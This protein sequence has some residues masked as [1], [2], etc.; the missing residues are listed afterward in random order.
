MIDV[1]LIAD[2]TVWE[3]LDL[4][5]E[6]L[7][8]IHRNAKQGF[9]EAPVGRECYNVIGSEAAIDALIDAMNTASP[10]SCT[11]AGKW[12]Q[13]SGSP[14]RS[15]SHVN[16][17]VEIVGLMKPLDDQTP[18]SVASPNFGHVFLG[19]VRRKVSLAF[20]KAFSKGFG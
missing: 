4:T 11:L 13:G 15:T 16:D 20:S 5:D 17:P 1:W 18:A 7:Y 3:S 14:V 8:Y 9:W 12:L 19:Q 10:G 6:S 2:P